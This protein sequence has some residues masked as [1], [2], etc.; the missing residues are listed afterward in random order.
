MK[1]Q[2][3]RRALHGAGWGVL[4]VCAAGVLAELFH[5]R[6]AVPVRSVFL[7]A[8]GVRTGLL[9]EL[10][11]DA[12]W[13]AVLFTVPLLWNWERLPRWGRTALHLITSIAGPVLFALPYTVHP[14]AA[15]AAVL[16][17]LA[18]GIY[19]LSWA[20]CCVGSRQDAER[21]RER[22]GLPEPEEKGGPFQVRTV[23]PYLL[24]AAVLEMVL[25]PLLCVI[26]A[27]DVPVLTGLL[28]PFLFLPFACFFAGFDI[29][30][31]FSVALLYPLVCGLFTIPHIFWL[32]N[33]SALF[34]VWTAGGAALLGNV[35]G[36]AWKK[37]RKKEK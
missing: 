34:Q 11:V 10:L 24:I 37:F 9:L 18:T 1:K 17:G 26:D 6:A 13:G 7:D 5:G 19:L 23:L 20:V 2:L 8:F 14:T 28:Y 35:L 12:L 31:R 36:A 16:A 33:S 30:K 15:A 29:G 27:P 21:I 32:Y 3:I 4:A 25:P 22:L